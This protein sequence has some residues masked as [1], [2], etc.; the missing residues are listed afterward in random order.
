M[1]KRTA[2]VA[3]KSNMSVPNI[4]FWV[5]YFAFCF[6]LP[7]FRKNNSFYKYFEIDDSELKRA[8]KSLE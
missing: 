2:I 8:S 5:I 6:V 7:I 1:Q 4:L 3:F